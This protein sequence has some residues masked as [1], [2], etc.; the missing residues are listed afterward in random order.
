MPS[1]LVLPSVLG[2]AAVVL[3][4]VKKSRQ[5]RHILPPGPPGV[6]LIGHLLDIPAE[7]QDLALYELGKIYG[8]VIC[9]KLFGRSIIVLNSVE[10]AIDLLEKRSANYSDRPYFPIFELCVFYSAKLGLV[11]GHDSMGWRKTL[12][13]TRYG[14]KY[15]RMFQGHLKPTKIITY[16]HQITSDE[17]PY[18][19]IMERVS[20]AVSNAGAPGNTPVDLFPFLR[21]F[22]SWFPGAYYA[23]LARKHE[24]AITKLHDYPFD[25]VIAEMAAG[26]A[27]PSFVQNML[28]AISHDGLENEKDVLDIKGTAA[29]M[30]CAGAETVR[31]M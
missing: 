19:D 22:P 30:Y 24:G 14:R 28:E 23:G 20:H 7:N 27:K 13:F 2:I 18:L 17:D 10:A 26:T 1:E 15:R 8:D 4:W 11:H 31:R 25:K 29:T 6:P 3:L 21:Y 9:L 12:T 5:K 16:G